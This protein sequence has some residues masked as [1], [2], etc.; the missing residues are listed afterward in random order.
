VKY[1]TK[2]SRLAKGFAYCKKIIL[3]IVK[4]VDIK[5]GGEKSNKLIFLVFSKSVNLGLFHPGLARAL[6]GVNRLTGK[7]NPLVYRPLDYGTGSSAAKF[8]P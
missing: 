7:D 2:P 8:Y 3:Q 5:P 6:P 4:N 1:L